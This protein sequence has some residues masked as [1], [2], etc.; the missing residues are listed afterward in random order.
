MV[1]LAMLVLAVVIEMVVWA[2]AMVILVVAMLVLTVV[3]NFA[4]VSLVCSV[5][6]CVALFPNL[7][8]YVWFSSCSSVFLAAFNPH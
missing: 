6:G 5:S 1:V 4:H 7:A 3:V 2:I 8:D